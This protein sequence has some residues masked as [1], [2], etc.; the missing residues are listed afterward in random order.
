MKINFYFSRP[1][2]NDDYNFNEK[3]AVPKIENYDI[4]IIGA[5][6]SGLGAGYTL[7]NANAN[8]L[9]LEGSSRVGGRINTVNMINFKNDEKKVTVEAGAQWIHGRQNDF[10]KFADKHNMIR[11]EESDEAEGDYI[12]EDGVKF[13]DFFVRKIDFKIGQLL[14][15]CEKFVEMKNYNFPKSIAEY[16]EEKFKEFVVETIT[17]DEEKVMAMQLF[18]W[19]RK[20]QIIDNSCMHFND[21]SAKDW[22]NYSFNGESAQTHINVSDGMSS[23]ADKLH[24][25]LLQEIQFN[26]FVEL[27]YWK[28]EE[29]PER[30]N[31][32]LI[33]CQDGSAYT[34]N[35]LI[36]TIS[37]GVLKHNHLQLFQPPLPKKYLNVIE[38]IGF[39]TINK[40]FIR[41]ESRWWEDGWKGLQLLWNEDHDDNSHYTKFI[42]GFDVAY[43][44]PDNT[45]VG[46]IG[47]RGAVE[48]EKLDD[49]VISKDLMKIIR[50]FLNRQDIPDPSHFYC[51]RWHSDELVKGAYSFTS[52]QTDHIDDWEK[53]LSQPL[54]FE[55]SNDDR[56]VL[57]FAGEAIHSQYFSTV[58]GAF[59]SGIEQ[60]KKILNFYD[61]KKTKNF[62][63]K[64]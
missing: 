48:M 7:K 59:M 14:E 55:S 57:L 18:D 30:R 10:Y 32:I 34:T 37:M 44:S 36:C 9:I 53:I 29:Y 39:G 63:S 60:A 1:S 24:E 15:E 54:T 38:N 61:Q 41:F 64:L 22:G 49:Q 52:R 26:K 40:I 25:D 46:W 16:V 5:G 21:I 27:I 11:P 8:F 56:N 43:P 51:S 50:K 2:K 33:K 35:N 13:D 4:I 3:A 58:H 45:L 42:S 20:F 47:G 62:I 12:R 19:H 31:K 28:S 23:I 6:I 17:C